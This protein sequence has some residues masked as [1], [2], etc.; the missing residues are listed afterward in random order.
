MR[1]RKRIVKLVS[2]TV[3]VGLT[4]RLYPMN[5]GIEMWSSFDFV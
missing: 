5:F 1:E 3:G 4:A 2:R